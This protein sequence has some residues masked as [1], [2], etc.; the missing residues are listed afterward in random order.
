MPQG[1]KFKQVDEDYIV[2]QYSQWKPCW[3]IARDLGVSRGTIESRLR[4]HGVRIKTQ[5]EYCQRKRKQGLQ[6]TD[7]L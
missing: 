5:K 7:R 3:R 6:I 2:K 4:K 1:G